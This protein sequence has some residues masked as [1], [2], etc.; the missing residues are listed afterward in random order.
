VKTALRAVATGKKAAFAPTV[1]KIIHQTWKSR[2]LPSH[3]AALTERWKA[4]HPDWTYKLWTDEECAAFVAA[5][6]PEFEPRYKSFPYAI[7]RFDAIRYLVL[8][9]Y[10]GVYLDLDMFPLKSLDFLADSTEFVL[11]AEPVE[12]ATIHGRDFIVSNAFMA[13][14]P[15]H[16]FLEHLV[17]DMATHRSSFNDRNNQILDTTGPF[18]MSRVYKRRPAGVRLLH[19]TYFMPLSFKQIDACVASHDSVRFYRG[20]HD[21]YA[22]HM[23]EGCWWRTQPTGRSSYFDAL[24]PPMGLSPIP[25]IMHLTWKTKTVPQ[26]LEPLV[27]KMRALH[28][29][30]DFRLWTDDEMMDFVIERGA[31]AQ[32]ER[33]LGYTKMIQ[34]CDYFRVF[35]V[36]VMG[37]VYLDLDIDLERSF[38]ELPAYVTAFFPCEKVMSK[39][40]LIQHKNRDAVRVGNYAMGAIPGHPFFM[41]L[42]ERM[43][44][45][46][47]ETLDPYNWILETTGPGLLSTAYHDYLKKNPNIGISLLYPD[48]TSSDFQGPGGGRCLCGSYAGVTSCR[49]G[50]FGAHLHVGSWRN[51]S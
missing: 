35:V 47:Y 12:S 5:V 1:S 36:S 50:K 6:Y 15:N 22:V 39:E 17:L 8:R 26:A 32:I 30:W 10:G 31:P 20:A 34:R 3:L 9:T 37:G 21:S 43:Q 45:A 13:S 48:L 16:P 11:S 24:V 14:P 46:K 28:P 4:L 7:Q 49:I 25:K 18:F 41:Y 40:A 42:L 2:V 23:F 27:A 29:D 51:I 44:A 19:Y 33:Y 38:D